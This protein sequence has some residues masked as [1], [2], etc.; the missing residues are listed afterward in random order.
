MP[1]SSPNDDDA[2]IIVRYQPLHGGTADARQPPG[3]MTKRLPTG[4]I[5][6][7]VVVAAV[8]G[9]GGWLF[10][11]EQYRPQSASAPLVASP[12]SSP[13]PAPIPLSAPAA[14][15]VV[16]VTNVAAS[17]APAKLP[18]LS[19]PPAFVLAS[20]DEA[21]IIAHSADRLTVFSFAASPAVVVLDF[22][23][24]LMQGRMLNR[25]AALV[26]KAG[27]PRD[28][29]LNDAELAD[30]ILARGDTTA[31]FYYGHDY[32]A[33]A[34]AS[35]FALADRDR[36]RLNPEEEELRALL[37]QLG[38]FAPNAVGAIISLSRA[39]A[40]ADITGDT[41]A[42][43]LH[44]ELSH[45]AFFTDTSYATYVRHFW[46]DRLTP[47]LR[48]AVRHFLAKDGYDSTDE[49]LMLNEMQAYLMFTHNP[50]FFD[51]AA[52]GISQVT[53]AK[54]EAEFRRG[55]PNTWIRSLPPEPPALLPAAAATSA[56]TP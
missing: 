33:A 2:T 45:G 24:L 36:I 4:W 5:A 54:L 53:R 55:M 28:R 17:P 27:L 37:G 46:H 29:V 3:R 25:V 8:A 13:A 40:D 35:F 42:T 15:P 49:E 52:L 39:G 23:T 20:A 14:P 22:P 41:R 38:W 30:A 50:D 11:R 21:S 12:P 51:P 43:I 26:E 56:A 32:P 19:Q 6:A 18:A 34:L 48:D 7:V 1:Q 47:K 10:T 44:H 9:A 31:T 16:V